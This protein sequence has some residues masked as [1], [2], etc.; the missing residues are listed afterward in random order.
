MS[1]HGRRDFHSGV[2]DMKTPGSRQLPGVFISQL[3]FL[4]EA[5][6]DGFVL[7]F[8]GVGMEVLARGTA[9]HLAGAHVELRAMPGAGQ[10][11]ALQLAL[12]EGSADMGTIIGKGADLALHLCQ[13]DWLAIHLY[14]VKLAL[15]DLFQA[16]CLIELTFSHT[17]LFVLI[18]IIKIGVLKA[19]HGQAP[20]EYTQGEEGALG[21]GRTD[22]NA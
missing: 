4:G 15:F 18:F 13:T 20:M 6:E 12:V 22:G 8:D 19:P 11:A 17:A 10:R 7:D 2:G 3:F 14:R 1:L 9:Q 5:N 21:A 16:S